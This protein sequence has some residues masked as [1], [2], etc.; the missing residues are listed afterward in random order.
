MTLIELGLE[1][2][3]QF[4]NFIRMSAEQFEQVLE[5]VKHWIKTTV[6]FLHFLHFIGNPMKN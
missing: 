3:Q 6:Q 4:Q 5:L 1:D 2:A